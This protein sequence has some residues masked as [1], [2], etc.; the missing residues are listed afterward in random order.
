MPVATPCNDVYERHDGVTTLIST[1]PTGGTASQQAY[2][3]GMSRNG[4]VVFYSVQVIDQ[5]QWEIP[6]R[7]FIQVDMKNVIGRV[8]APAFFCDTDQSFRRVG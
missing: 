6:A 8:V 7:Y 4:R 3:T 1:G 2:F 5:P